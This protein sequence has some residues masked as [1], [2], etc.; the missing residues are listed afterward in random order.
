M[1]TKVLILIPR[2]NFSGPARGAGALYNGLVSAGV[3]AEL[4]PLDKGVEHQEKYANLLLIKQPNIFAKIYKFRE[5]LK[6]YRLLGHKTI[7]ISF[8]L[9]ADFLVIFSGVR[10]HSICSVRGNCI[11]TMQMIMV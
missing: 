7:V 6:K 5:Y 10:S 11:E 4:I 8:C 3:E 2:L 1:S 9:Q